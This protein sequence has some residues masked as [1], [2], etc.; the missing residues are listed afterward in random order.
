MYRLA[1]QRAPS[2][3]ERTAAAEFAARFGAPAFA[4]LLWNLNE[5]A[6]LD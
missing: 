2:A 5:F 4:R 3:A 6:Y 1:L